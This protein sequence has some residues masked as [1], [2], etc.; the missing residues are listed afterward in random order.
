MCNALLTFENRENTQHTQLFSYDSVMAELFIHPRT[1][2]TNN[3]RTMH[4]NFRNRSTTHHLIRSQSTSEYLTYM[5]TSSTFTYH[6]LANC[7][8]FD[9]PLCE[10]SWH[11]SAKSVREFTRCVGAVNVARAR[12][13]AN[14]AMHVQFL[15]MCLG[16]R[17]VLISMCRY[18]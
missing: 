16:P 11:Q 10:Y 15:Y 12:V 1:N 2:H 7:T 18:C 9:F 4:N 13:H 14:C 8:P 5:A 6:V 3:V 17:L